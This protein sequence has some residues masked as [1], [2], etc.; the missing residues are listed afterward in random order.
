MN[1]SPN[2]NLDTYY[3]ATISLKHYSLLINNKTK[4]KLR[5]LYNLL[6]CLVKIIFMPLKQNVA[7]D[8]ERP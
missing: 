8:S 7:K 2:S 4:Y 6:I 3:Y 1:Y 5:I